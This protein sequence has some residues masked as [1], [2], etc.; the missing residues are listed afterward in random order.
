MS[1]HEVQSRCDI[2][3]DV[4]PYQERL[5]ALGRVCVESGVLDSDHYRVSIHTSFGP[6]NQDKDC[7][8]DFVVAWV[9]DG[10]ADGPVGL[11]VALADGVTSSH[12]AEVGSRTACWAAIDS[13]VNPQNTASG[14]ERSELAVVAAVEALRRITAD[15]EASPD[16]YCPEDEFSATWQFQLRE[17]LLLQTTLTLFWLENDRLFV[18]VVGDGGAFFERTGDGQGELLCINTEIGE[19]ERVNA[20][21]PKSQSGLPLQAFVALDASNV[22][23]MGL[24]TDGILRGFQDELDELRVMHREYE[25]DGTGA[26]ACE[27]II[28]RVTETRPADFEDNLTLCLLTRQNS[29]NTDGE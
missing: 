1:T 11:A 2:T 9:S 25:S 29:Q 7:N 8:Q 5:N 26:N 14:K 24:F 13:L 20:L 12:R 3:A 19:S 23:V 15:V 22:S 28:E 6:P 21:G 27:R 18:A 10:D 16:E 17:G 4:R